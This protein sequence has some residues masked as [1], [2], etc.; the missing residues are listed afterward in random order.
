MRHT[1]IHLMGTINHALAVAGNERLTWEDRYGLIF[2]DHVSK[3]IN[4]GLKDLGLDRQYYDP[5]T[6]YQASVLAHCAY[7][8]DRLETLKVIREMEL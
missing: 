1:L 3:E 7:L 8:R 4:Y 2:S 5:D 6:T